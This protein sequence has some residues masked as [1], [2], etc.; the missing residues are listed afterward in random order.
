MSVEKGSNKLCNFG[1]DYIL[2]WNYAILYLCCQNTISGRAGL[3][4]C[5]GGG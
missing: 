5:I 1:L 2:F 4:H 3:K